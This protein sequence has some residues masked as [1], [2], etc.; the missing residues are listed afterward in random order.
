MV[1][2]I[3]VPLLLMAIGVRAEGTSALQTL[4]S[5]NAALGGLGATNAP[6]VSSAAQGGKADSRIQEAL[7][8][9]E[10]IIA[11]AEHHRDDKFAEKVVGRWSAAGGRD[12]VADSEALPAF[13]TF[14]LRPDPATGEKRSVVQVLAEREINGDVIAYDPWLMFSR[15]GPLRADG[16]R[17]F[18]VQ[19][20]HCRLAAQDLLLCKVTH[21]SMDNSK[22]YSYFLFSRA[23]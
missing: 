16:V 3:A 11:G 10:K 2:R 1:H 14:A 23:P 4:E 9:A 20:Y 13:F 8:N 22:K 19:N 17:P 7:K 15:F 18:L 12:I 5:L 6:P 21:F